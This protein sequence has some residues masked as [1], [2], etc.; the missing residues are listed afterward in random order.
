M[1]VGRWSVWH[2]H[3]SVV[4]KDVALGGSRHSLAH[5]G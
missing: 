3:W 1:G 2:G 5:F 4:N